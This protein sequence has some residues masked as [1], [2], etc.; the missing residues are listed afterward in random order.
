MWSTLPISRNRRRSSSSADAEAGSSAEDSGGTQTI[1]QAPA[2]RKGMSQRRRRSD[3]ERATE[4]DMGSPRD[5][6]PRRR[7]WAGV[8]LW[9]W[10]GYF[11][12]V[13]G[14]E[15]LVFSHIMLM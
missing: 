9:L 2:A 14:T 13:N 15:Y 8:W 11:L 1:I 6:E 5:R 12:T 3:P 7:G 4:A 10:S